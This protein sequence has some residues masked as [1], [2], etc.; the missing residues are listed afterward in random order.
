MLVW[1]L[2]E[3]DNMSQENKARLVSNCQVAIESAV[4][5]AE[6][7]TPDVPMQKRKEDAKQIFYFDRI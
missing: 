2:Q 7:S 5:A 3:V 6:G 1:T 4:V